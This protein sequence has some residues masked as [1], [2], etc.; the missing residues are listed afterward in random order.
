MTASLC[1]I[2]YGKEPKVEVEFFSKE[3]WEKIEALAKCEVKEGENS[4]ISAAKE[5]VEHSKGIRNK[6][7]NLLGKKEP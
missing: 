2:T 5:Y 3:E 4:K 7:P 6:I 1:Y